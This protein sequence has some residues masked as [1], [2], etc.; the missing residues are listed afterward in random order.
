MKTFKQ[1]NEGIGTTFA[2]VAAAGLGTLAVIKYF[3]NRA[4]KKKKKAEELKKQ[5]ADREIA[6][7]QVDPNHTMKT[8]RGTSTTRPTYKGI[9]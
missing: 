1:F 8:R 3:D 5:N 6:G 2:G 7:D 4:A 9:K